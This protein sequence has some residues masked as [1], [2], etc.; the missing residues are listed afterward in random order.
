[1]IQE[2]SS[3]IAKWLEQEGAISGENN[4]LFSYAVYSLLFGLLPI[5]I[6]VLLGFAF[7][8]VREGLLM[9]TPFMLIRKF[10]G[11]YHLDSPKLCICFS[12]ALLA[13]AIGF[14]KI[15]VRGRYVAILTVL[16]SLSVICLCVFSP[17]DNDSRRLTDKERQLFRKIAH[18]LVVVAVAVYL[19]MYIR[20]SVQYTVAFGMGIYEMIAEYLEGLKRIAKYIKSEERA[21]ISIDS[22]LIESAAIKTKNAA[23]EGG[24]SSFSITPDGKIYPC[25]AVVFND[26]FLLGTVETGITNDQVLKKIKEVGNERNNQCEGCARYDYCTMTRCKIINYAYTGDFNLPKPIMC[27]NEHIKVNIG[28]YLLNQTI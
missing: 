15:I 26:D 10:S 1:M 12:I 11:G 25:I 13:L 16:V 27:A 28:K 17:V 7:G 5:F 23:C 6:V 20:V 19:I 4:G 14:I 21:G 8:M 18:I 24:I 2:L 3:R 9:I 22:S